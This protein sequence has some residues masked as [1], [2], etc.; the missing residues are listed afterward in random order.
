MWNK[1]HSWGHNYSLMSYLVDVIFFI[2]DNF[3]GKT[4]YLENIMQAG[5]KHRPKRYL[6]TFIT[7]NSMHAFLIIVPLLCF[8]LCDI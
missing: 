5:A 6:V 7:R 3:C 8:E 2:Q 4:L 1:N